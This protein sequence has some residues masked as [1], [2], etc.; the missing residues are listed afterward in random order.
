[1]KL[2]VVVFFLF[3]RLC[4]KDMKDVVK[5]LSKSVQALQYSPTNEP[6][7][8]PFQFICKE[9]EKMKKNYFPLE[10]ILFSLSFYVVILKSKIMDWKFLVN[11]NQTLGT[12]LAISNSR[13]HFIGWFWPTKHKTGWIVNWFLLKNLSEVNEAILLDWIDIRILVNQ[14]LL[15]MPSPWIHVPP[16]YACCH[17]GY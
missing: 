6:Q 14:R 2:I 17:I 3:S 15:L 1:M 9:W 13:L 16:V 8:V 10:W 11:G 5:N 12:C 7:S 4:L